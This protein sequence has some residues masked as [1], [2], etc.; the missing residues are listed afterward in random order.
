MPRCCLDD[1][2]RVAALNGNPTTIRTE[3]S[4]QIGRTRLSVRPSVFVAM[5][6]RCVARLLVLNAAALEQ[7]LFWRRMR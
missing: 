3:E 4:L 5:G 6:A 7:S 1:G 2:R